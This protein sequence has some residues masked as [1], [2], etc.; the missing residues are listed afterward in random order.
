M[1]RLTWLELRD[2]LNSKSEAELT[3]DIWA[4]IG[5]DFHSL[6]LLENCEGGLDTMG[7]GDPYFYALDISNVFEKEDDDGEE[8]KNR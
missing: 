5:G 2:Y 3:G 7:E 1:E 8:W 4:D 6:A